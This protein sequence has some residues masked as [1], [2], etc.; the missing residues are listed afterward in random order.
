MSDID[1]F[2]LKCMDCIVKGDQ[3]LEFNFINTLL[4][5]TFTLRKK[6]TMGL[7]MLINTT[8]DES[9]KFIHI[10][11]ESVVFYSCKDSHNVF[12]QSRNC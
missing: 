9:F 6:V 3:K 1:T 11:S 7:S 2:K 8:K 4:H 5:K 10:I 12:F